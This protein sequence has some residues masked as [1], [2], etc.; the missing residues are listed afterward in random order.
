MSDLVPSWWA[1]FSQKHLEHPFSWEVL[2]KLLYKLEDVWKP[3]SLSRDE[4]RL[5]AIWVRLLDD[6]LGLV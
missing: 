2:L 5:D 6:L 1:A 4:V 3:G